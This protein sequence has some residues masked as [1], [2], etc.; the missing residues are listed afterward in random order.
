MRPLVLLL[1]TVLA[2]VELEAQI[3][4][5]SDLESWTNGLPN[6]MVGTQTDL[7]TELIV[8]ET[9][10]VHGGSKAMR[11]SL[12]QIDEKRLST[13]PLS[14][15]AGR[16]YDIRF[17][18]LGKGRL[19]TSVF[20]G[21][22]EASGFSPYN[23]AVIVNSNIEWQQV[24]QTVYV[25]N[26]TSSAEF[27]F[28]V[29]G[30]SSIA[31]LVMDDITISRSSLPDPI[32]AT[33]AEIQTTTS[34]FEYSPL[35]F[36]FVRTNGIVTGVANNSYFIQD[37][38]G[39]WNGIQV[40]YPPPA[41]LAIGDSVT[42]MATV[43]EFAGYELP[44]ER[45]LTQLIV[46]QQ[47]LVHS[48][49]HP[50]PAPVSLTAEQA[51]EEQW[52]GVLVRIQDLECLNAPE[53]DYY[54]WGAANW[55]G[56]TLVDDLLY[57]YSPTVGNYYTINGI[58]HY[59]GVRKI[60]LRSA[61]DVEVGVGVE[62]FETPDVRVYPNPTSGIVTIELSDRREVTTFSLVDLN[63][64]EVSQ[65][66]LRNGKQTLDLREWAT[67]FYTAFIRSDLNTRSVRVVLAR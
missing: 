21:R 40:F 50:E 25:T 5:Q 34:P 46:V 9:E 11:L 10:L 45:T 36:Q 2:S 49:G 60:L 1:C 23:T 62:E 32:I 41:T 37:G 31:Y 15:E 63:G 13:G 27:I 4:F 28:A 17:W 65:Q 64:R 67:G 52:E 43:T 42:V 44:W 20:D 58:A 54:E 30:T 8:E 56:N 3:I 29:E 22:A 59:D 51:T 33:I 55:Q 66:V 19:R 53:P 61:T 35:N 57:L 48:S 47:L 6:G 7:P 16:L 12:G 38:S 18:L 39:P 24:T 14:V 26:T